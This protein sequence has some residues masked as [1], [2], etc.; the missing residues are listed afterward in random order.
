MRLFSADLTLYEMEQQLE[1]YFF[2]EEHNI[3][4]IGDLVM[5]YEDY[6]YLSFKMK[7]I[8]H[9]ISRV[10]IMEQYR[11]CI[12]TALVFTIRYDNN[13]IVTLKTYEQFMN[14]FQ[15][16]QFRFCMR[17]LA[18][19]FHEMGLSTYGIKINS[20]NE[21]LELLIIHANISNNNLDKLFEILDQYFTQKQCYLLEEELYSQ[22][23]RVCLSI[24]PFLRLEGR[25]LRLS[26]LLKE[27]Y[28]AC[29]MKHLSLEQLFEEY[30]T[31]SK[32]LIE[33]CYRWYNT[34]SEASHSLIKIR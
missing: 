22:L 31:L 13:A 26:R 5:T 29:Y 28:E 14:Q 24:Y 7:G 25:N 8:M 34:Y 23:D 15:Q 12:L 11:F 10:E 32:Q 3:R 4:I 33:N 6:K 20:C 1:H 17:M 27:L 16:H 30:D 19:T 9:Y 18:D 2:E 21:L